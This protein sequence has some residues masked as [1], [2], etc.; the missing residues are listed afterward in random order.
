MQLTRLLLFIFA[1]LGVTGEGFA[2]G[3]AMGVSVGFHNETKQSILIQG[4]TM[5]NGKPKQ[6]QPLLVTPGKTGFDANVPP[7]IRIITIYDSAKTKMILLQTP[8]QVQNRDIVLAVR[9]GPNGQLFLAPK[10]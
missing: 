3:M 10:K 5:V 6:G 4:V 2:Q 7:G 9:V 1:L 8:V